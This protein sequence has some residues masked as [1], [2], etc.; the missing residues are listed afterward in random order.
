LTAGYCGPSLGL[1]ALEL[2]SVLAR[3]SY[4]GKSRRA[5]RESWTFDDPR[6]REPTVER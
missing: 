1:A 6:K 4:R 3:V 2:G 5:G